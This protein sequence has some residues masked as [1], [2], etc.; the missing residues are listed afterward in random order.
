MFYCRI[1]LLI[2]KK[3]SIQGITNCDS[4]F[5]EN[6]HEK[7]TVVI[8]DT[9]NNR[10]VIYTYGPFQNKTIAETKADDMYIKIIKSYIRHHIPITI[11]ENI[12]IHDISKISNQPG[13]V[14][15]SGKKYLRELT[16][17]QD[18]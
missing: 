10:R 1:V 5:F 13:V 6:A 12:G 16:A 2:D 4:I 18:K 15:E 7:C 17:V 14:T 8:K 9:I 3:I 11:S